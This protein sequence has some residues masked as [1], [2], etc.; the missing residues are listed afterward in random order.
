MADER[1]EIAVDLLA[2]NRMTAGA[3]GAARDLDRVGDAA[4]NAARDAEQ[5]ARATVVAGEGA[6]RLGDKAED[7]GDELGKLDREILLAERELKTLARAFRDADNAADRLDISRG[8][9]RGQAEIR[10]LNTARGILSRILP[11][12]DDVDKAGKGLMSKL[13][14]ALSEGGDFIATAAGNKVGMTIGVAIGAAAAP[15]LISAIGSAISAGA[16]AGAI[17][18]AVALTVSKDDQIKQAG[19]TVGK[20]FVDALSTSA[21]ANFKGPIME[22]LEILGGAGDRVAKR[23]QTAFG[24]MG[25]MLVPLVKDVTSSVEILSDAFAGVAEKSGPA[26]R[27]LGSAMVLLSD[28][29]GDALSILSDGSDEAAGSLVLLAG[30]TADVARESAVALDVFSKLANNAWVTGPLLPLLKKHYADNADAAK[31]VEEAQRGMVGPLTEAEKA[32]RGQM[33][34]FVG[35]NAELHKQADP[36]F[37]LIDAQGKLKDAQKASADAT[38]KHGKKSKEAREANRNLAKAALELQGAVGALG[39]DFDGKLTP[40]MRSTLKAAHLTDAQIASVESQFGAAKRAGDKYAKTY[41]ATTKV[42]GAAAARRSLY[43]VKEVADSIPRAVTIAMRITGVTNVSAAAAAVRKNTR[44]RGGPISPDTPY[45]VGEEGPELVL[46]QAN[47]RVLTA[48][49]SRAY[50]SGARSVGGGGVPGHAAGNQKLVLELVGQHEMVS[51]FRYLVR[52]ANL[53]EGR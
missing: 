52:S 44:A 45:W 6:E 11:G 53:L 3:D 23:W 40:A 32:A 49:Q 12:D 18:A 10:R 30:A 33:E 19:A 28:G 26:L 25:G 41:A 31:H 15:V 22:S 2:R 50:A 24:S 14:K 51:M 7:A 4:E 21:A 8:I 36:V 37:A 47:G 17:G 43:S 5:L 29:V 34:A 1:R 9:R 27:G 13:G 48:S 16:G 39:K 20:K 38:E 46:P 42:Y 35:L